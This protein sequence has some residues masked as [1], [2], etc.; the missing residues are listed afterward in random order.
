MTESSILESG[1]CLLEFFKIHANAWVADG[2]YKHDAPASEFRSGSC[3]RSRFGLVSTPGR[4]VRH[5]PMKRS[6][7]HQL[8]RPGIQL[9]H[10]PRSSSLSK[11]FGRSVS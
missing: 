11:V 10:L 6:S 2:R 9:K 5:S 8:E 3:T 7:P 4:R 1:I